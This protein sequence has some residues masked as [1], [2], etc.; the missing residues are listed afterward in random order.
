MCTEISPMF[1]P[2]PPSSNHMHCEV[3]EEGDESSCKAPG[4]HWEEQIQ[5]Y[6]WIR[7]DIAL[8]HETA[9]GVIEGS[10]GLFGTCSRIP[11]HLSELLRRCDT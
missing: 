10:T 9:G 7:E 11:E 1:P 3:L 4:H 2:R 6:I 8:A 5:D